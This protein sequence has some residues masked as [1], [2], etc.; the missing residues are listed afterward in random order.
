MIL[1][2]RRRVGKTA[3]LE[4]WLSSRKPPAIFWTAEQKSSTALLRSFSREIRRFAAP[5]EQTPAEFSYASWEMAFAEIARLAGQS[6]QRL[7]VVIDEF[8]YA[9][10]SDPALPSILQKAWDHTLK[11]ANL[12]LVI[13]GSHAGMI[14]REM[15]AYR[16]P[17]YN[18]A[19]RSIHLQA[20]PFVTLRQFFPAASA[21]HRLTLYSCV[22]GVPL[23][24]DLLDPAASLDAHLDAIVSSD[25]MLDDA[26]ALLRDQLSEPR[27]YVAI[28]ESIAHGFNR[29]TEIAR[30]AGLEEGNV[31]KY[32]DTLEALDI[33]ERRVPATTAKEG[34]S[35]Q[36]RYFVSDAYLRFFY[37]FLSPQRSLI[38]RGRTRQARENIAQ[39]LPEWVGLNGFEELCREWVIQQAD[40]GGL[41]FVPRRVGSY[42]ERKGRQIDVAAVNEDEH[43]ILLG[44]CKWTKEP[45]GAGVVRELIED[46]A[47]SVAIDHDKPWRFTFAFFSKSGFT[48]EARAAARGHECLW[49]D[50]NR[51]DG[52]LTE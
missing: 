14:Q 18:R 28:V 43:Q 21:E 2:G 33:I 25:I 52:E 41:P 10:A 48:P 3:L 15:L 46:K 37:R 16:S 8:T 5:G 51:L 27:N 42:W 30:M 32:L 11:K 9:I 26:G 19:S 4:H 40:A 49:V 44:E 20:L 12:L 35:K 29:L 17:L 7:A 31:N 38:E 6:A 1:Y 23:Y 39:H 36:G 45:I 50:L 24:L 22:G 13:T 47:P 34:K